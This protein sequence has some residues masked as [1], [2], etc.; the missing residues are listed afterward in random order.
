M[1]L[2]LKLTI[3][4]RSG[5][6]DGIECSETESNRHQIEQDKHD[7]HST[8]DSNSFNHKNKKVSPVYRLYRPYLLI[9]TEQK[10]SIIK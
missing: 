7:R 6:R 5:L 8:I 4:E 1:L 2:G 10:K 3:E 9:M